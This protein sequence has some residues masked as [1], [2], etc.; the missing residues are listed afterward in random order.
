MKKIFKY[1][2]FVTVAMMALAS[3]QSLNQDPVFNDDDAFVSFDIASATISEDGGMI[4]IPVT[5]ASVEGVSSTVS[6]EFIDGTA[7]LGRN[8][9]P[10]DESGILNFSK[11]NRTAKIDVQIIDNPGV[12]TGDL[13]FTIKFKSTGSVKES[14]EN[15]CVITIRDND[16]PLSSILGTYI[17]YPTG[18][19]RGYTDYEVEITKD[20]DGDLTMVWFNG[21]AHRS[22]INDGI[23]PIYGNV[24]FDEDGNI[25]GIVVPSGQGTGVDAGYGEW[26]L[27]G[28]DGATLDDVVDEDG[29]VAESATIVFVV[30]DGGKTIT[31]TNGFWT[32]D[33][34]YYWEYIEAPMPMIKQ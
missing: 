16:H 2:S 25:T 33:E 27:H 6:Y 29:N 23:T 28:W 34:T 5:L 7:V 19:S 30:S 13:N 14:A 32:R 21:L 11:D 1:F 20:P 9:K 8:Y 22:W 3:C 26:C 4:T 17:A 31:M 15:S 18:S 24:Q 12:F 10:V